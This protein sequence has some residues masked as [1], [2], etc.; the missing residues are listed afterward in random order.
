[1]EDARDADEALRTLGIALT[2]GIA[3]GKSFVA[4]RLRARG[5]EVMD[6]DALAR[7]VVRPGG[8]ALGAIVARFGAGV[9]GADGALDRRG[10]RELIARDPEARGALEA[11]T[12]PAIHAALAHEVDARGVVGRGALFFYEAALVFEAGREAAFRAVWATICAPETQ[13]MRLMARDAVPRA[14]AEALIAAQMP[15]AEKARRA[16][17]ALWTDQGE[18]ALERSLD[19]ALESAYH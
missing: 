6:A 10:M 1:M 5:Y 9:L 13:I 17:V 11:I 18:E 12:H 7:A 16:H 19:A 8:A 3:T 14:S 2:G 4:A 15:A